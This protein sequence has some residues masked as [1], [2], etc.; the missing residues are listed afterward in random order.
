MVK[1]NVRLDV[2]DKESLMNLVRAVD[3]QQVGALRPLAP[4]AARGRLGDVASEVQKWFD[5]SLEPVTERYRRRMR[6]GALASGALVVLA[7]NANAFDILQRARSDPRFRAAVQ[8]QAA[9]LWRADSLVRTLEDSARRG[10]ADTART[11]PAPGLDSLLQ[12]AVG[13]RESLAVAVVR[14]DTGSLLGYPRNFAPDLRWAA[15]IVVATLL[16]GL[17]APFWHDV[18]EMVFGWKDMARAAGARAPGA[19]GR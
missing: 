7:V 5:L 4:D 3:P 13:K 18:L 15:G 10:V 17:G 9:A 14:A 12:K 6:L 2:L 16:V 1:T 11:R 19:P 8:Q